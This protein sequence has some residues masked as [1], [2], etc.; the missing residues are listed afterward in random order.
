MCVCG[1]G[2]WVGGWGAGRFGLWGVP[3][4]RINKVEASNLEQPLTE[5]EVFLAL[6]DLNGDKA[7]GRDDFA[8]TV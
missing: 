4:S 1:G 2:G 3:F 8:V 6:S 5:E 7:H